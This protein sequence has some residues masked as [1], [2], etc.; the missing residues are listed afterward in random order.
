MKVLIVEDD[1]NIRR[2][3]EKILLAEGYDVLGASDG[4]QGLALFRSEAPDFV[5]LDIMMPGVNGYDLCKTIRAEN[6][7]MP[8]IFISA[9]SEEIDKVIGLELGADDFIVKPFG[10]R[11]VVARIRAVT[12][13]CMGA[14]TPPPAGEAFTMGDL[15]VLPA[16]LRARRAGVSI[17][18]SLRDIKI[19]RLLHDHRGQVVDRHAFFQACWGIDHIPNSR[20]LDQHISQLRQR[21]EPDP[22]SPT[23][24][25]TVYGVGYRYDPSA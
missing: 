14:R 7:A 24:I 2:G 8:V 21:I 4:A 22:K 1:A 9:K 10:V 3:L 19:L 12:R 16:E 20:T 6:P 25:R 15:E 11:E 23:L 17:D 13:R 18:L 5:C